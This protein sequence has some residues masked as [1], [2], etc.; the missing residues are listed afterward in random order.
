MHVLAL[1]AGMLSTMTN[2]DYAMPDAVEL[3][4]ISYTVKIT[5]PKTHYIEVEAV[6]PTDG[7]AEVELFMAVWTPGSYMVREYARHVENLVAKDDKRSL[8]VEKSRKNRWKIETGSSPNLTVSYRIYCRELS[9]RT[10]WVDASVAMLNGAP[11]F[12]TLADSPARPHDVRLSLPAGWLRSITGLPDA[13][14][15]QP[16]HYRAP[17]FETLVDCPILAGNPAVYEFEVDGKKHYVVNEGEGGIWDGPRS[18]RDVEAIV[19]AQSA[20]WG[21]L[22]YEKYVFFNML[23]ESGGG[24]EHKNSTVLMASRWATR[25]RKA[26]LGWLNLVSHEFFHTWNVKR[27]RPVELGPFDYEQETT[28]RCL[29]VAEGFTEYYGRLLVRRAGLCTQAEY[30]AGESAGPGSDKIV[31]D[32]EVVQTTPGRLVQPLESASFD[33]WIKYYRPDENSPNTAM[34]YYTKGAVVA[35]LLDAKIRA[36]TEGKK[37]LDDL[38]RLAYDKYSGV[39]GYTSGEFR[40]LAAEVAGVDLKEWFVKALETT[41]ELGYAEALDVFGL[42]FK[43]VEPAKDKEQEPSPIKAWLG[44]TTK[45]DGGRLLVTQVRRGTPGYEAGFNTDDEI[46]A[47]GDFRIRPEN[48]STRMEQYRPNEKVSVLVARRDRLMTLDATFS[49]EP[50]NA[51]VIE[52]NPE[53]MAPAKARLKAW[54]GM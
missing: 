24:L 54:L 28:T 13:P 33:A 21:Q 42:R 10:N 51:W 39:K 41:D 40:A 14:D 47:I 34:S 7:K 18:A 45:T 9:V 46:V 15:H 5:D 23:M 49:I 50:P 26:Y 30:L 16:H 37:T 35:W 27:L 1:L 36:A 17:D 25:T 8:K 3:A 32:I 43:P 19:R 29:W 44:L 48:W 22:P 31:N 2:L 12:L 20:F 38:M 6:I 4:P 53:A 52:P 11:T